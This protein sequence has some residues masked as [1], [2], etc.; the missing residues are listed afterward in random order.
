ML[1][2]KNLT[3]RYGDFK[4][5]NNISFNVDN[6]DI[7]A[8]IGHNGA[9]KTTT[10][11][12]IVGILDFEEGEILLDGISIKNDPIL[13][14]QK[15]AYIPDSPEVYDNLTGIQFL[16]FIANITKID[17][18]NRNEDI[19]TYAKDFELS[20]RLNDP[21]STYSHGMKQKLLLI[22]AF[23]RKPRM[24]ILDEPFVGLDPN[25]SFKMKKHM[26]EIASNGTIIFFSTHVL[27]VA[28]KFCNK[29][30]I[31]KKGEIVR[32]GLMDEVKGDKSLESVFMELIDHE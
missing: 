6:G 23:I 8:F 14:K 5:V 3:K 13:F 28:E 21:I 18:K 9:G 7:F 12:S 1:E 10:I 4:A 24:L 17:L 32:A 20:E 25:A 11:K 26:Q 30:A 27:E 31:I 29:I 2:I 15:F 22:S 19:L 16:N